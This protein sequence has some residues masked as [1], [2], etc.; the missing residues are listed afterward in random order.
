MYKSSWLW[1]RGGYSDLERYLPCKVSSRLTTAASHTVSWGRGCRVLISAM[2]VHSCEPFKESRPCQPSCPPSHC[3]STSHYF[4]VLTENNRSFQ[5]W[6]QILTLI[7]RQLWDT[8][9]LLLAVSSLSHKV[10]I[11]RI[12][13]KH[14]QPFQTHCC[15]KGDSKRSVPCRKV[16]RQTTNSSQFRRTKDEYTWK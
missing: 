10:Q 6:N 16:Y 7:G 12:L 15:C 14:L 8:W 5:E 9:K 13:I 4:T 11:Q 3:H 1:E 2:L